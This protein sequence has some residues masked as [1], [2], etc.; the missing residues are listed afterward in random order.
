[1]VNKSFIMVFNNNLS[2]MAANESYIH[3][4]VLKRKNWPELITL[5]MLL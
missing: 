5:A 3:V 1:M 4:Y 2:G